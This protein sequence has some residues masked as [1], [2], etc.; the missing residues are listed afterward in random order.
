MATSSAD[1]T[2]ESIKL[3]IVPGAPLL[4]TGS[5]GSGKLYTVEKACKAIGL[6][7][8]SF[9]CGH[10]TKRDLPQL[11]QLT[12]SR[13]ARPTAIIVDNLEFLHGDLVA[14]VRHFLAT[15]SH[16]IIGLA[17]NKSKIHADLVPLFNSHV[18]V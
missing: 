16:T 2:V 18:E 5:P 13:Y 1:H 4:V 8:K 17:Y 6:A 7:C 15:T 9:S 12:S 10:L 3:K 11:T 14:D